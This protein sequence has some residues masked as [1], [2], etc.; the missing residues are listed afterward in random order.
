MAIGSPQTVADLLA[1]WAE[2]AGC[3]RFNIVLEHGAMDE[4]E[5]LR[6]AT[7]FAQEVIPRV[8]AKGHVATQ[9]VAAG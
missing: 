1:H 8:R 4:W 9:V 3:S 5:T 6:S 7:L 2:E